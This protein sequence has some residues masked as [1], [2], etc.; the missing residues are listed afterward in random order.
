[1]TRSA[2]KKLAV[3][4][5]QHLH[6]QVAVKAARYG[7]ASKGIEE[8]QFVA[9]GMS[10]SGVTSD[11][12]TAEL[13]KALRQDLDTKLRAGAK[14]SVAV[15][16]LVDEM[17]YTWFNRLTALRFMEANGYTSR[18]LS[19]STLGMVDPDLLQNAATLISA[20]E[21]P[22][23][24]LEDLDGWRRQSEEEAYRN[25]LVLECRK[26]AK[27]LPFLFGNDKQYAALFLPDNLLNKQSLV[28]RLVN[29]IPEEDWHEIEIIGWLY[30]FYISERKDEVFAKK[31]AY[32]PR[33]IPA[34]TQLFTPHWIVRYMVENSLGRLWLEAHPES[35]LREKMPYY[36]ENK[37]N[38]EQ[39]DAPSPNLTPQELTVMDPACGSGHI[40]TYSFDLLY[41]IY[42]EQGYPDREIPALILD[43]NLH[44]LDID[45]RATQLASFALLMKAREKSRRVLRDPPQLN[46]TWTLSTQGWQLP[47]APEL[48]TKDWQPLIEAFKDADNL[49]S[50]ITPPEFDEA[51]LAA[52]LNAFEQS[53]TVEASISGARLRHLLKQAGLL[54]KGYRT[55]VAN[56][57]YMSSKA[58]NKS[59]K[60]FINAKYPRSKSDLFAVFIEKSLDLTERD[61]VMGMVNQHSWMFLSSYQRLREHL[62]DSYNLQTM[63]HLGPRAFPEISGEVVQSTAFTIARRPPNIN[64]STF[65]RLVDYENSHAK[66]QALLDRQGEYTRKN[67][68][69]FEKIP[70]SPIA[71]WTSSRILETFDNG[72]PLDKIATPR[73]GMATGSNDR[74][75]RLWY[76]VADYTIDFQCPTREDAKGSNK[77][78]FRYNKGGAFRAW[79]GNNEHVVNW[80][81]DG[82]GIRSFVDANGKIRSHNYN[83][84]FVFK[85]SLT[86]TDLGTSSPFAVRYSPPGAIF[87]SSGKSLFFEERDRAKLASLLNSSI[88]R[89]LLPIINPTF[90]VQP[91]DLARLPVLGDMG[92]Y[93]K[94]DGIASEAIDRSKQDWD[95]FETSPDFRTHPLLRSNSSR[96]VDAFDEWHQTA[97]AAFRTLKRLEEEN[98]RYWIEAYDLQDELTPEVPDDHITIRR[99]DLDR[100]V[101]SLISYA[102][103]CMMC[104]YSL[105]APGLQFAGGNF[106]LT[107]FEGGFLP[108][109]D[110]VLPISDEPYFQDDIVTRFTAFLEAAYGHTHLQENLIFI[111]DALTRKS[112][113]SPIERI[114]RYF[115][116]EFVSDHNRT[117]KKRPIYWLFTSGKQKAFNALVYL[118][119]YDPDTLARIR[120]DYA[121]P[122]QTKLEA[123]ISQAKRDVELASSASATKAAQRQLSKLTDQHAEL[124]EYQEK[125]QHLAD[126]RIE[127]DLDDGVAYN[128]TLFDGLLYEGSDLKMKDMDKHSEWKRELLA[129]QGK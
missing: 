120:N 99:A 113:E 24:D 101:K 72:T 60:D 112:S 128:Y 29:D 22:G 111:A 78:W 57:P 15:D 44:G 91:G 110:G 62:L 19:S 42:K 61:G 107:Q 39:S 105:A 95:N 82:R 106:D 104:R 23:T 21:Y 4:A 20:G 73:E 47:E 43:H 46:V 76:E 58:F 96:L 59:V 7:I 33:D 16:A 88:P 63:I 45:E 12:R 50:L 36:L 79:Y 69:D 54:A 121:L 81:A 84:D 68:Q 30:Q 31:G 64:P 8:P 40:L 124:L 2:V 80:S 100:D 10:V 119:R 102:V 70:G 86:W 41:E 55:V 122:L 35:R 18:V 65:H 32:A 9:G 74:F 37:T 98:N 26:L 123:A 48:H 89:L 51:K 92:S 77:T 83:L 115:L 125:L 17:A 127:L 71:Y 38:G 34:A 90:H 67:Q 49:G 114:R 13:Y 28:R 56:P 129:Q 1:M 85:E 93:K 109:P 108:D 87:D 53:G 75:L 6:E 14:T 117:Y 25:L 5:R 11:N 97:D 116:S 118:H 126:K 94:I 52:Q 27:P 3:W 66:Q 103:G